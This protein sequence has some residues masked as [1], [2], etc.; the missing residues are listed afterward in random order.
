MTVVPLD[1]PQTDPNASE[2]EE[3]SDESAPLSPTPQNSKS[4]GAALP[5]VDT[6]TTTTTTPQQGPGEQQ[7]STDDIDPFT[8]VP[9]FKFWHKLLVSS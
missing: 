2:E 4:Y 3:E 9:P 6:A 1:L 7:S 8:F 5:V